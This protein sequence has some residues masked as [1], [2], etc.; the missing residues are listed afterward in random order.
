MSNETSQRC[1]HLYENWP[2]HQNQINN[3]KILWEETGQLI[4][5]RLI[6]KI[7]PELRVN[8]PSNDGLDVS[9]LQRYNFERTKIAFNPDLACGAFWW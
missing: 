4:V 7:T 3:F 2:Y 9:F 1:K 5:F 6:I 8:L